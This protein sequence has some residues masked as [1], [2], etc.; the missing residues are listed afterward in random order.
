MLLTTYPL[1]SF[2]FF[3]LTLNWKYG[4]IQFKFICAHCEVL[5]DRLTDSSHSPRWWQFDHNTKVQHALPLCNIALPCNNGGTNAPVCWVT[6]TLPFLFS[7][8]KFVCVRIAQSVWRLTG[9]WRVRRSNPGGGKFSS[10]I[11]TDPG[12]YPASSAIGTES[13]SRVKTARAWRWKPSQF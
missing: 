10:F 4:I 3:T 11:Q 7:I 9:D 5:K 13:F 1:I 12:A 6:R 2:N 8:C